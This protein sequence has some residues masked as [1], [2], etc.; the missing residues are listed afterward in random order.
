MVI[1]VVGLCVFSFILGILFGIDIAVTAI[2]KK[3]WVTRDDI[4]AAVANRYG[5][6]ISEMLRQRKLGKFR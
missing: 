5:E 2:I 6:E 4:I 3:G 1:F